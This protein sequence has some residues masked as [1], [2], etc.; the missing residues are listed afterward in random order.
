[1]M[2][3]A[4][5]TSRWR[6]TFFGALALLA[7]FSLPTHAIT[8][9]LSLSFDSG[10]LAPSSISGTAEIDTSGLSNTGIET[11]GRSALVGFDLTVGGYRFLVDDP[12]DLDTLFMSAAFSFSDGALTDFSITAEEPANLS[13]YLDANG[14]QS[15]FS[16]VGSGSSGINVGSFAVSEAPNIAAVPLPTGALLILTALG[17]LWLVPRKRSEPCYA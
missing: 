9:Q 7:A 2:T 10:P 17:W 4:I 16:E 15:F 1:M 12:T 13:L 3:F 11:L 8:L 14:N 6:V 5:S